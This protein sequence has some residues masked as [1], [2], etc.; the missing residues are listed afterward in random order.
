M[1][2]TPRRR[3]LRVDSPDHDLSGCLDAFSDLIVSNRSGS[4]GLRSTLCAI[5]PALR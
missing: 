3:F 5:I 2:P 4:G 1:C